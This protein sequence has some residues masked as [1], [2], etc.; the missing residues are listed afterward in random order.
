MWQFC[1]Y[2]FFIISDDV[3][4]GVFKYVSV[5]G[6]IEVPTCGFNYLVMKYFPL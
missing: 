1:M 3:P 6:C 4:L 5:N 2:N